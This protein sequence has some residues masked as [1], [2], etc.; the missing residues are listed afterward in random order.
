M[1]KSW[2]EKSFYYLPMTWFVYL[3]NPKESIGE[4]YKNKRAQSDGWYKK[5]GGLEDINDNQQ[6][7]VMEKF[8]SQGR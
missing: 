7:M 2:R 1:Y 5:L 4:T 6:E 8:Y 3:G